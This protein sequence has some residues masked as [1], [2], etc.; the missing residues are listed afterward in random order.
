MQFTIDSDMKIIS[1]ASDEKLIIA[2]G[3]SNSETATFKMV[4]YI[5]EQ[6]MSLCDTV[7]IHYLNLSNSDKTQRISGLYQITDM[8]VD[9][10]DESIITFSW[11]ISQNATKFVGSL[12][13]LV[14][15]AKDTESW[16]T[17]A[18]SSITIVKTIDNTGPVVEQYADV[19]EQWYTDLVMAGTTGINAINEAKTEGVAAVNEA[20]T[21]AAATL[22]QEVIDSI[23]ADDFADKINFNINMANGTGNKSLVGNDL[24]KNV[25]SGAYSVALG[26]QTTASGECSYAE[27]YG[28]KA[29]NQY[30]H[31]EGMATTASGKYSHAEGIS[32]VAQR[33]CS[34]AEGTSTIAT[35]N[36][37]HSE[38][39]GTTASGAY[40]HAEGRNTTAS[41][42]ASHAGGLFNIASGEAQTAIGKYNQEV[43]DALV[44]IGN[45]ESTFT[46][47]NI[48]EV[49]TDSVKINGTV[50]LEAG[51][52]DGNAVN[53]KQLTDGWVAKTNVDN[54][55]VAYI[56]QQGNNTV[57]EIR[58]DGTPGTLAKYKS[59]GKLEAYAAE[60]DREVVNLAQMKECCVQK[61]TG[62]TTQDRL[63]CNKKGN[64]SSIAFSTFP[65]VGWIPTYDSGGTLNANSGSANTSVVNLQKM[66]GY[67]VP[68]PENQTPT[69]GQ[70]LEVSSV[71][72]GTPVMAW[73][74]KPSSLYKWE[75]ALYNGDTILGYYTFIST[76]GTGDRRSDST[77]EADM[78]PFIYAQESIVGRGEFMDPQNDNTIYFAGR[79]S[80]S[81]MGG[82][83]YYYSGYPFTGGGTSNYSFLEYTSAT[84]VGT[85]KKL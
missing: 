69:D 56:S 3:D 15:F 16:N 38:G 46:R 8:K 23:D 58:D 75:V 45:G 35:G 52:N 12:N 84:V 11:P 26:K 53:L 5:D 65:T 40:S 60:G 31:A 37:S 63:Y 21:N 78:S 36:Y 42:S 49:G 73:T 61:L 80:Q 74:D 34:H 48:V 77:L 30:S 10:T 81:S 70:I 19:L 17:R 67:A 28:S 44:I 7:Q 2:Q 39:S 4:R 55:T 41:G 33:E 43:T 79:A 9:E 14:R 72:D 57:L 66:K 83:F 20:K 54:K 62:N 50:E 64:E 1:A 27:G 59:G 6:D 47:S 18:F 51:V 76:N 13:F 68:L 71:A 82:E 25:A 85:V 22:K 24:T 32:T 29:T